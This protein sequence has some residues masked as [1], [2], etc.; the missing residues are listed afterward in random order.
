MNRNHQSCESQINTL[1]SNGVHSGTL[2][3]AVSRVRGGRMMVTRDASGPVCRH[4]EHRKTVRVHREGEISV[5]TYL[6]TR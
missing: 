2:S 5:K 3:Y 6:E 4:I 1:P